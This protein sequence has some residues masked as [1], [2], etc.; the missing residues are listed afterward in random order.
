M[1]HDVTLYNQARAKSQEVL[2]SSAA[3][4]LDAGAFVFC[5]SMSDA[6]ES[7]GEGFQDEGF[8]GIDKQ[9]AVGIRQRPFLVISLSQ[10]FRKL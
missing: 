4:N 3:H 7:E 6:P 8:E 10:H 9:L 2:C 1:L 5:F